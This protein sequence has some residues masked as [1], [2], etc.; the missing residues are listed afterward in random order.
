MTLMVGDLLRCVCPVRRVTCTPR[1]RPAPATL[2]IGTAALA[3]I[4]GGAAKVH[5]LIGL[6]PSNHGTTVD[7]IAAFLAY[8]PSPRRS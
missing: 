3:A 4:V 5:D 2:T 1:R 7:G 8:F 6:A